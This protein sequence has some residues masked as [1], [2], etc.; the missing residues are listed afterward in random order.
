MNVS[1]LTMGKYL[2]GPL[3]R[4]RTNGKIMR[5]KPTRLERA[6][7][8]EVN[9]LAQRRI[10]KYPTEFNT[11]TE[12]FSPERCWLYSRYDRLGCYGSLV[13]AK[14]LSACLPYKEE[15]IAC[16][17]LYYYKYKRFMLW[18]G[19][20]NNKK[21]HTNFTVAQI[22]PPVSINRHNWALSPE[23]LPR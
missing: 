16:S 17:V 19:R 14:I 22:K 4:S 15:L 11:Q 23:R 2:C 21:W 12:P 8:W 13:C 9:K 10:F 20:I 18:Y 1:S 5:T 3:V 7:N 6:F